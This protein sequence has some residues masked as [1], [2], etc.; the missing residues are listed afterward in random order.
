[1]ILSSNN[2]PA[3]SQGPDE[4]AIYFLLSVVK[5]AKPKDQFEAMLPAQMA[6]PPP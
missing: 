2:W 4:S 3:G 5:G 1:L 6:A